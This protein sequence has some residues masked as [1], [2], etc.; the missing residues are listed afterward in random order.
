ML[1]DAVLEIPGFEDSM[2]SSILS[3][4]SVRSQST[5]A[6]DGNSLHSHN[7]AANISSIVGMAMPKYLG[8]FSSDADPCI[9]RGIGGYEDF[10]D[11]G[12]RLGLNL[13]QQ[14]RRR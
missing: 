5:L 7:G 6:S 4:G 2:R 9:L 10:A 13:T 8:S 1:L 14:R 11:H 12:V 3:A